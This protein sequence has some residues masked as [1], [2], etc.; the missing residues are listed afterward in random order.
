MEGSQNHGRLSP[1]APV[2][3]WKVV[4]GNLDFWTLGKFEI[5]L[6]VVGPNPAPSNGVRTRSIYELFFLREG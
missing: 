5:V 2:E 3:L 4:M 6:W 1:K